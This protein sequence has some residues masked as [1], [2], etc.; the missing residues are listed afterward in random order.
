MRGMRAQ[1]REGGEGRRGCAGS[2][3]PDGSRAGARRAP[4][5]RVRVSRTRG[6][7]G[8]LLRVVALG[9]DQQRVAH[10]AGGG[11]GQALVA[12]R[13]RLADGG[14]L[15]CTRTRC[16]LSLGSSLGAGPD[17]REDVC[18]ATGRRRQRR[19]RGLRGRQRAPRVAGSHLPP[20]PPC[21]ACIRVRPPACHSHRDS[22]AAA[23]GSKQ[24]SRPSILV[25]S[26]QRGRV[27]H[28]SALYDSH[29]YSRSPCN[30]VLSAAAAA[31]AAASSKHARASLMAVK[32]D[33]R[34]SAD[35]LM[36]N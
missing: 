12:G 25:H 36:H 3:G 15:F 5:A 29:T 7:L 34:A 19:S 35:V 22:S 18:A 1:P 13:E 28:C 14:F 21:I 11:V 10:G 31:V 8:R 27:L 23:L 20:P 4:R 30:E 6:Q 2:M 9:L 32:G 33:R 24:S 17:A 16:L 26:A